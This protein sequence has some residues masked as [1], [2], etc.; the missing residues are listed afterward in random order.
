M[1]NCDFEPIG[2]LILPVSVFE[3]KEDFSQDF[4]AKTSIGSRVEFSAKLF[5]IPT[6]YEEDNQL[7]SYFEEIIEKSE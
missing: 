3:D 7:L 2:E 4:D 5:T 6:E 1:N